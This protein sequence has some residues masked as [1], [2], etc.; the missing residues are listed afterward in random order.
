M[1]VNTLRG[2]YL[3]NYKDYIIYDEY[4]LT[5][6]VLYSGRIDYAPA[7]GVDL[8]PIIRQLIK[9]EDYSKYFQARP[10]VRNN[11]TKGLTF[12]DVSTGIVDPQF[13]NWDYSDNVTTQQGAIGGGIQDYLYSDQYFP[14]NFN[15][16]G[17]RYYTNVKLIER[18]TDDQSELIID[19]KPVNSSYSFFIM[20]NI[21][22]INENSEYYYVDE[23]NNNAISR[24]YKGVECRPDNVITLYYLDVNGAL[25]WLHCEKK[26][27][28]ENKITRNQ[29]THCVSLSKL[30]QFGIDNYNVQSYRTF[31]L[32]TDWLNDEQSKRVQDLLKS[33]KIWLQEYKDG[34]ENQVISVVCED[35]SSVIKNRRNDKLFNYTIKVRESKTENIYV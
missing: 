2:E 30:S 22:T 32:N 31:T 33:P 35:N 6:D 12:Y 13:F 3:I 26:N 8:M 15:G 20:H 11:I 9:P 27:V 28:I 25:S 21:N 23:N 16:N 14:L 34:N 7:D 4:G 5:D 18:R 24:V 19:T 1:S 29:I 10:N 17:L